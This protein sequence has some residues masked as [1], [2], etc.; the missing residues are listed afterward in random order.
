MSN[1]GSFSAS[2]D[3]YMSQLS[4]SL[5]SADG[6]KVLIFSAENETRVLLG[7]LL[8]MWG[9][10]TE[11]CDNLEKSL[12]IIEQW[13]PKLILFDSI[14]PFEAHLEC[15]RRMRKN[16]Y[17]NKIPIIVLSGFSQPEFR[18]LALALGADDFFVKPLDFDSLE[19]SLKRNI[20][21]HTG[22]TH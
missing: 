16:K 1:E 9:Y 20:K 12:S 10:K 11:E 14:L 13:R 7:T 4:S 17:S 15:L 2:T 3:F 18:S 22:E 8:G 19:T 6:N 21:K 5:P